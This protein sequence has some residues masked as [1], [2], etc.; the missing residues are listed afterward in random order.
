MALTT[1]WTIGPFWEIYEPQYV[2]R[3]GKPVLFWLIVA[4][5]GAALVVALRTVIRL[6]RSGLL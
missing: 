1:G 5:W 3:S 6:I 2:Y 4:G